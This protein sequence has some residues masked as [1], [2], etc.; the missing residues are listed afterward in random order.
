MTVNPSEYIRDFMVAYN[1]DT[2]S[3]PPSV[4]VIRPM[5][6]L[7]PDMKYNCETIE[8]PESDHMFCGE[9][10]RWDMP[11]TESDDKLWMKHGWVH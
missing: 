7:L 1:D 11:W 4:A 6:E 3:R 8:T 5:I 2:N 9:R 10:Q